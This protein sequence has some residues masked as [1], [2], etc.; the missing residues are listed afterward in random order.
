M[1]GSNFAQTGPFTVG[2][3]DGSGTLTGTISS[4]SGTT[5]L[6]KAGTGVQ[7][8]A[9]ANAYN[10]TT[11]VQAGTLL[12]NNTTGS[13][14]GSGAVIVNTGGTFGGSGAVTGTVTV[15]SGATLAPGASVESLATGALT[16]VAGSTLAAEYNSSATP[17]MDVLTVT[18]DVTLAGTLTLTD[19]ATT[20]ATIPAGTRFTLITYSG[21]IS[22][23]FDGLTEGATISAGVNSFRIRYG[24]A[25]KVTLEANPGAA[26][27]YDVW[28]ASKGLTGSNNGKAQDPDRDGMTNLTE[29]YLDGNPLASDLSILPVATLDATHLTLSF[30]R[31]D[32]AEGDV[33]GQAVQYGSDL[34]AWPKSVALGAV[35]APADSNGVSV[36][37]LENGA[38]PDSISV[39]IPRTQ[40]VAG[41]LFG[42]LK[43]TKL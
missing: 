13:A 34:L 36:T 42:R 9:G 26:L 17:A 4:A 33:S 16:L 11:T 1:G 28:A 43:I 5:N 6:V 29:F 18:G 12:A 37:V 8:L 32:D 23:T 39:K 7:V 22:G 19:L 25:N 27:P 21:A 2:V 40:A 15:N 10:G 38:N 3:D 35:S 24:D 30:K 31:R 14:T 20:P 41:R